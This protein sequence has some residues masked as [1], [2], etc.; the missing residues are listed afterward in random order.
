[1]TKTAKEIQGDIIALLRDSTLAK[2]CS[3]KIY[4]RGY[5]PLNSQAEDIIVGFV[6]GMPGE[7]DEG[8]IVVNV[9]VADID[10]VGNGTLVENGSRT[11]ELEKLAAEWVEDLKANRSNYLFSLSQSI[12]TESEQEV[13][14]HFVSVRLSYRLFNN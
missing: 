1:M 3:G 10:A 8:V 14:Q 5:R 2:S 6:T 9:Y 4:R 13:P 7:I 12:Y 11:A